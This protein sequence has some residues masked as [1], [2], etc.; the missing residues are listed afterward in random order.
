MKRLI[1]AALCLVVLWPRAG[2]AGT[3]YGGGGP[4]VYGG[5][6]AANVENDAFGA[7][8]NGDTS[9]APSQNA[10]YDQ[11]HKLDTDDDGDV[12]NTNIDSGASNAL[13]YT[14]SGGKTFVANTRQIISGNTLYIISGSG[15]TIYSVCWD[16]AIENWYNDAAT[17]GVI[18]TAFPTGVRHEG[19]GVSIFVVGN[20]NG[21]TY[22]RIGSGGA[23][24][25]SLELPPSANPGW[26]GRDSDFGGADTWKIYGNLDDANNGDMYLQARQD[27][28]LHTFMQFDESDDQVEIKDDMDLEGNALENARIIEVDPLPVRWAG[29]SDQDVKG[30]SYTEPGEASGTS[31]VYRPF[32]SGST[33]AL[34]FMWPVA[35]D[36]AEPTA[37][38]IKVRPILYI[39]SA[40]AP[41]A[42]E[43]AA[44]E[45]VGAGCYGTGDLTSTNDGSMDSG[46]TVYIVTADLSAH[47]TNDIVY[48]EWTTLVID[49]LTK[50][51]WAK[52]YLAR[53]YGNAS[54]DYGQDIGIVGLEI[55]YPR[56]LGSTTW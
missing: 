2:S 1:L 30:V 18:R 19:T 42:G 40:T 44:W 15:H 21:T 7:G 22:L 3:V 10:V 39:C 32:D 45:V 20:P 23:Y 6:T 8:W 36:F 25:S 55:K 38:T 11:L 49:D 41:A 31:I 28:A 29:A 52:I 26:V 48:E 12:D 46:N 35:H 5:S 27:S 13:V 14:G 54:D 56:D 47:A 37:N 9:N 53:E 51:E 50:G 33:E 43:G 4:G 17:G 16:T 24:V 34:C